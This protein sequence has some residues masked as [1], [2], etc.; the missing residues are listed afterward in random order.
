MIWGI[1]GAKGG[2]GTSSKSN[3]APDSLKL[4]FC[5]GSITG[6]HTT[7]RRRS[8]C[9]SWAI[10]SLSAVCYQ[11]RNEFADPTLWRIFLF[12]RWFPPSWS[13]PTSCAVNF[14]MEIDFTL[15]VKSR[16]TPLQL[17]QTNVQKFVHTYCGPKLLQL[18]HLRFYV[19]LRRPWMI[20]SFFLIFL[21]STCHLRF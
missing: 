4:H 3:K 5:L 1:A 12:A 19:S 6:C 9:D 8:L 14:T 7:G 10:S 2:S 15:W 13:A 21:Y 20:R 18:L 17:V 11:V 16:C